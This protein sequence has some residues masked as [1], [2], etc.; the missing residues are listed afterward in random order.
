MMKKAILIAIFGILSLPECHA[1]ITVKK[2]VLQYYAMLPVMPASLQDAYQK[3]VCKSGY[4]SAETLIAP[5]EGQIKTD[6][7][8][9]GTMS[10]AQ[11]DKVQKGTQIGKQMQA[12]HVQ[13]MNDNQKLEYVKNNSQLNGGNPAAI[14]F[15]QK[16]KNDPAEKAKLQDMTPEQKIAYLQQN[17]VMQQGVSMMQ[18][19]SSTTP[20]GNMANV[21]DALDKEKQMQTNESTEEKNRLIRLLNIQLGQAKLDSVHSVLDNRK[22][23]ELNNLPKHSNGESSVYNNPAEANA[24]EEKYIRLHKENAL[25]QMQSITKTYQELYTLLVNTETP[26]AKALVSANYGYGT[27]GSQ[28]KDINTLA[29]GQATI[30]NNVEQL[31]GFAKSIYEF[32]AKW[33][34]K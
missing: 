28:D 22:Q 30:L 19:S 29:V 17:G 25:G 16:M 27:D 9:I 31:A 5:V 6:S 10:T 1:Q 15:A 33:S 7:K 20:N 26:F 13:D 18:Q 24:I 11:S 34:A 4:C 32:G 12:D 14:E 2:D 23:T 8:A 3:C 21:A